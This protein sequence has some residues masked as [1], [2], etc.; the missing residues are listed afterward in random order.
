MYSHLEN[1]ETLSGMGGANSVRG[2]LDN[3]QTGHYAG[4][5]STRG[6]Y[7]SGGVNPSP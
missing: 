2:G 7:G 6:M 4:L 1:A 3:S 5:Q